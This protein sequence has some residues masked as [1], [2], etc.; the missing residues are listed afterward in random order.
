MEEVV[1]QKTHGS[2]KLTSTNGIELTQHRRCPGTE[3]CL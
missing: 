3:A 1:Y 2:L